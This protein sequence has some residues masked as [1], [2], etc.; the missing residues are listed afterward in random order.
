M[1]LTR[2]DSLQ[3]SFRL[4]TMNYIVRCL[5]RRHARLIHRY[6]EVFVPPTAIV[7]P[8]LE[9]P[10]SKAAVTASLHTTVTEHTSSL[11]RSIRIMRSE[12]EGLSAACMFQQ[13]N[14]VSYL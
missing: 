12:K 1:L 7:G 11:I 9:V 2:K 10:A 3:S 6:L 13:L 5:Q 4:R 8:E 14:N